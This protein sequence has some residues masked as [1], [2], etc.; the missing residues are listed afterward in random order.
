MDREMTKKTMDYNTALEQS[1]E[2]IGKQL[3]QSEK[4]MESAMEF[5][6]AAYKGS[7]TIANNLMECY[8]SNMAAAFDGAKAL[9][10]A[11]DMTEFYQIASSNLTHSAE[12]LNEQGKKVAE[13]SGQVMKDTSEAGRQAY[14]KGFSFKA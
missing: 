10:K 6:V 7:E 8:I 5:G 14:S 1:R 2:L 4:A 13:L 11:A 9:N 12:R 3:A